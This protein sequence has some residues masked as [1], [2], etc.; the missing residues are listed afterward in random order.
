MDNVKLNEFPTSTPVYTD[1]VL[2][3]GEDSDYR[4]SLDDLLSVGLLFQDDGSGNVTISFNTV[5]T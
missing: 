5:S 1:T 3:I 2:M 4:A